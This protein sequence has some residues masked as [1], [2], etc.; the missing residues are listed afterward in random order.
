M[1]ITASVC[2]LRPALLAF[3]AV[4]FFSGWPSHA[5]AGRT[6]T[7]AP[8]SSAKLSKAAAADR[9]ARARTTLRTSLIRRSQSTPASKANQSLR[10]SNQAD[11]KLF[12]K[13]FTRSGGEVWAKELAPAT[14]QAVAKFNNP[15]SSYGKSVK[16][17]DLRN[18]SFKAIDKLLLDRGFKKEVGSIYDPASGGPLKDAS[19]TVAKQVFYLHTDGGMIRIKPEGHPGSMRPAP[20]ASKAVRNPANASHTDFNF[21]AFKVDSAG[22]AQ[23]KYPKDMQSPYTAHSPK[24]GRLMD[25][26]ASTVHTYLS[27]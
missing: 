16:H 25:S 6:R 2:R 12:G 23:P 4:L 11:A 9:P 20:H 7:T 1:S 26:W 15:K 19:G 5:E 22:N 13:F 17:V 3:A 27:E 8:K 10:K 18:K 24:A 14:R 21:E